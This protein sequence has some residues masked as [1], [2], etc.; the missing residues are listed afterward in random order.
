MAQIQMTQIV[1][2]IPSKQPETVNG[3]TGGT[4]ADLHNHRVVTNLYNTAQRWLNDVV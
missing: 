4:D 2:M 1:E 3:G